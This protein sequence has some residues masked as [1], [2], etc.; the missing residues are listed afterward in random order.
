MVRLD[1]VRSEGGY[2]EIPSC[3]DYDLWLRLLFMAAS[4]RILPQILLKY[5]I[6]SN[7]MVYVKATPTASIFQALSFLIYTQKSKKNPKLW[8]DN[9][10]FEKYL[11]TQDTSPKKQQRFNQAYALFYQSI[12][13]CKSKYFHKAIPLFIQAIRL[14]KRYVVDHWK[15]TQLSDSEADCFVH[16]SF[17]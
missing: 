15:Q 8:K 5:R 1:L 3:E 9:H 7:G 13:C 11:C 12:A 4:M 16:T 10:A 17:S 14:D 6:R 2:R